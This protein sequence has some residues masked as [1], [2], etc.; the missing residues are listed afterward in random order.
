MARSESTSFS[1]SCSALTRGPFGIH[2]FFALLFRSHSWPV[3]N[4]RV[5]RFLVPLSL[6]ARSESTSFA[7]SCFALT[8]GPFGIHEFC[9][10]LFR[11]HSWP[12]R[13]PRVLRFLVPLS[14]VARSE[15]TSFALSCSALT[16]GPN[17]AAILTAAARSAKVTTVCFAL[18]ASTLSPGLRFEKT[19]I[20]RIAGRFGINFKDFSTRWSGKTN[21]NALLADNGKCLEINF[22]GNAPEVRSKACNELNEFVCMK[23][24][25]SFRVGFC[26]RFFF[27]GGG[28]R[29]FR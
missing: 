8:R 14:L 17:T 12:V 6:V 19:F 29:D 24:E 7:L 15:S 20:E 16:R 21:E 11:S 22:Q 1:L 4:P 23:G 2:E 27:L 3:R 9:A 13:N 25:Q 18:Q 28:E 26:V 10:L 5:L